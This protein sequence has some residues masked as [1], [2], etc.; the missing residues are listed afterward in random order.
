MRFEPSLVTIQVLEPISTVGL[1]VE[2]VTEL[3]YRTRELMLKSLQGLQTVPLT[4][5]IETVLSAAK[6][7]V[8][9]VLEETPVET[10]VVNTDKEEDQ[11]PRRRALK[12]SREGEEW[13]RQTL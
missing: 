9:A 11:Q 5:D 2:D 13:K 6:G 10:P 3:C 8:D 7:S 1:G 12:Q 4:V